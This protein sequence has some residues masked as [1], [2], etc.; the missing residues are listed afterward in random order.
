MWRF[1]WLMR[2]V[3]NEVICRQDSSCSEK[4]TLCKWAPKH[5]IC[6]I[7]RNL[8]LHSVELFGRVNSLSFLCP[9]PLLQYIVFLFLFFPPKIWSLFCADQFLL[10]ME[11]ALECSYHSIWVTDFSLVRRHQLQVASWLGVGFCVCFIFQY[12]DCLVWSCGGPMTVF[13]NQIS[14]VGSGRCSP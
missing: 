13:V 7:K 14:P 6:Y 5:K 12:W 1:K 3:I 4:P 2:Q 9:F 8:I 11:F 10:G